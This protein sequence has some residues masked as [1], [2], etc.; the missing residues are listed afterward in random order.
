MYDNIHDDACKAAAY[1][2]SKFNVL[3][4]DSYLAKLDLYHS[5]Y[6]ILATGT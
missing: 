1:T 6:G 4:C 2:Y 5:G 3:Q